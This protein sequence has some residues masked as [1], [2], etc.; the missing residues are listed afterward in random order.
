MAITQRQ[1]E[2]R[3]GNLGGSDIAS[4]LGLN[5]Y[6]SAYDLWLIKT[7]KMD[8]AIPVTEAMEIGTMFEAPLLRWAEEYIGKITRR[9]TERRGPEGSPILDHLDAVVESSGEPVEAKTAGLFSPLSGWGDPGT[10]EVPEHIIIQCQTHILCTQKP[11]CHIAA[12]LGG[13]GRGLYCIEEDQDILQIIQE[14]ADYFWRENVLADIPPADSIGSLPI[15]KKIYREPQT[16]TDVPAELV[17][18]WLDW[19]AAVKT[20]EDEKKKAEAALLTALGTAEGGK[21]ERGSITYLET[22]RNISAKEA[23]TQKFRT[24]K[25]KENKNE[26]EKTK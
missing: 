24:L 7:G 9:G 25:F 19:K 20:A 10:D 22:I 1:L 11:V 3:Q 13:R 16:V 15:L 14:R 26:T 17:V 8:A 2:K 5:P 12:F 21:C 6:Q 4:I 23:Y 18:E